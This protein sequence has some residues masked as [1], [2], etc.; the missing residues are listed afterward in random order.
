MEGSITHTTHAG[1]LGEQREFG[2][3]ISVS[4]F[5]PIGG[6]FLDQ[7]TVTSGQVRIGPDEIMTV[8]F[9]TNRKVQHQPASDQG[10]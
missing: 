10:G 1:W 9:S 8:R 3:M 4:H 6:Y 2:P 7:I 5:D